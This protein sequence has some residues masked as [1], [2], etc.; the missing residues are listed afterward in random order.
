MST[1][2]WGNPTNAVFEERMRMLEG[3]VGAVCTASEH[4]AQVRCLKTR[5]GPS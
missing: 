2:G 3:G 5:S 1:R 4:A